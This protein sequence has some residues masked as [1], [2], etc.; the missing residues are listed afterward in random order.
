M[1]PSWLGIV[2]FALDG[3]SFG[4]G[5]LPDFAAGSLLQAIHNSQLSAS[6]LIRFACFH[7]INSLE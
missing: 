6:A 3:I 7:S 1:E 2:K 4:S 5:Y